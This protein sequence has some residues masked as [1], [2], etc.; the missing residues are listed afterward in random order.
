MAT[1]WRAHIDRRNWF[2]LIQIRRTNR[3]GGK[4]GKKTIS[5]TNHTLKTLCSVSI[6]TRLFLSSGFL[7]PSSSPIPINRIQ[8]MLAQLFAPN[9]IW[10]PLSPIDRYSTSNRFFF[11]SLLCIPFYSVS[12]PRFFFIFYFLPILLYLLLY[13]DDVEYSANL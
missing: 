11:F 10:W 9:P 13:S 4:K 5:A 12:T 1:R 3:D 2:S 6:L 8:G 7:F